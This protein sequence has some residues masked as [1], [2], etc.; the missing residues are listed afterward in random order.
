LPGSSGPQP[1]A[2]LRRCD[3]ARA[4]D[5]GEGIRE[6]IL[7]AYTLRRLIQAIVLLFIVSIVTFALIHSA[8]GGPA[9][10]SNPDLSRDQIARMSEQLGLN[11]PLPVQYGRWMGN[12]L[13]GDLGVS[14]NSITPVTSLL[15][16]RLPNTLLLAGTALIVSI[17]VAVPLGVISAIRRNSM[18]DRVVTSFSFLGISIPVFWLGI[19]LIVLLSV[20]LQWL[21]SGGMS[22]IGEEFSIRDRIEHL[23]LPVFVLSM[24]NL[25]ELTRYTRSGMVTVL[26]EEYIRTARAK[27][28]AQKSVVLGHALRNALIPVVTII[29]VLLPRAVSG[30][31]I[32]EAVFTWPGMGSLA[33]DA[34]TT[35]D[36]PVV[37]GTTLTVATVVVAS[38]LITDLA[39]GYL[40]PRIRV[41]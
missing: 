5:H 19:M 6:H 38:S 37:L 13:Q 34:A 20:Q 21:P 4:D 8:P 36:Y 11:D 22:T 30:A 17:L 15:A 18:L 10:L 29:G 40:D 7:V 26:G 33:V 25:A 14:Y 9:L 39:Y 1:L 16:D 41:G 23:I 24:A 2:V 28:L 32:T 3:A 27:G 12:L 31:A 35:R